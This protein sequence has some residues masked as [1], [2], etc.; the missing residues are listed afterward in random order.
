MTQSVQG[1]GPGKYGTFIQAGVLQA[2]VDTDAI[3]RET[4]HVTATSTAGNV[5]NTLPLAADFG[6]RLL[7]VRNAGTGNA[8]TLT[9]AGADLID[10]ATT[11]VL[12]GAALGASIVL[13]SDGVTTW[14]RVQ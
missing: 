12:T 5:G 4:D 1:T 6:R 7:S 11:V 8:Q 9:R 2:V 13:R 10:A 3:D 14:N